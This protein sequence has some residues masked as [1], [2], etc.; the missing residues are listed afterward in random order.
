MSR[1]PEPPSPIRAI[2]FDFGNVLAHFDYG[3][4]FEALGLGDR[5]DRS[6]LLRKARDAG[7]D[8]L[9][10]RYERGQ[11][12]DLEFSESCERLLGLEVGH[13]RFA[14]AWADIFTINEPIVRLVTRLHRAGYRLILGSNTN[15][16]QAVQFRRQFAE[17]LAHFDR[18]VLSFEIGHLK[19]DREFYL[20][21]ADAASYPPSECLF[22][23]DLAENVEGAH[24]AGLAAIRYD[25]ADHESLEATM[26]RL[27]IGGD[28]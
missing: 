2:L 17:V 22:I 28:P 6:A 1:P 11:I 15:A 24:A 4:A 25:S 21:C 7:L 19:P 5:L 27:G 16:I 23:D 26:Q 20:A 8:P 12:D 9:V 13:D 18:L 10:K 14:A 3:K